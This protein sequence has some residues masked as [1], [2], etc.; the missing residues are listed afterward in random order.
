MG[1]LLEVIAFAVVFLTVIVAA[2]K[3]GMLEIV[4]TH[5]PEPCPERAE[6]GDEVAVHYIGKL[7][8]GMVFDLSRL[9]DNSKEPL[10]FQLGKN[11]VIKG[12]DEGIKGMCLGEQRKLIIP[13]HLGYGKEGHANIPPD[14]TLI[15]DVELMDIRK[16]SAFS[17]MSRSLPFLVGP[18]IVI[19][20][21]MY[22]WNKANSDSCQQAKSKKLQKKRKK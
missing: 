18:G 17:S 9:P 5:I 6:V 20:L 7:E 15:F 3:K 10:R 19:I 8:S 2:K 4:T 11:K 21:G 22:L 16:P 12:W 1:R 13:S 14:S